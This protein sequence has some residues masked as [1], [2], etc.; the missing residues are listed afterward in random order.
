VSI[1]SVTAEQQPVFRAAT[2]AVTV[3][4]S[5]RRSNR[6]VTDLV[7]GDFTIRDNGVTQK[8]AS[9]IYEKLPVD[10]TV[11]F[12]V[13]GSITGDVL[14]QLR[15]SVYE[16]RRSVGPADRLQVLTFNMLARRLIGFDEPPA[17]I[18]VSFANLATGGA[19]AVRD[20][21]AVALVSESPTDRRQL[22]VLF[23]DGRDNVS[24][25]SPSQLI[26]IARRTT[27]TFSA[28][29][30]T[31]TR[32][33]AD[34]TYLDLAA[35]TGGSVVS[36]LPTDRLGDLLRRSVEQFRSSY[37]LTYTPAGVSPRGR[38]VI[39]V[40]VRRPGLEVRAR[41]GYEIP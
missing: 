17:A 16:L 39:D 40:S 3:N 4:V 29:L 38:H 30:A 6:P 7:A 23:S 41:K 1:T 2:D 21:L 28:V 10:L 31:P 12:D 37:V 33:P 25:T 13:S 27:P 20:T 11:L 35:E 18:D 34:K 26:D 14:E 32:R 9:L 22:T 36:L 15:R 8:I 5:V 24:M 19:S